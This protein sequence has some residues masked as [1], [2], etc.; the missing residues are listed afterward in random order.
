MVN[1]NDAHDSSFHIHA[2]DDSVRAAAG[3]VIPGE[4]SFER[5]S[6]TKWLITQRAVAEFEDRKGCCQGQPL[7]KRAARSACEAQLVAIAQSRS[8]RSIGVGFAASPIL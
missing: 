8:D 4:L 1:A 3:D 2:V 7:C 6:E 5:L